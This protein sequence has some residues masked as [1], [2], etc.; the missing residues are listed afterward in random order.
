MLK[1]FQNIYKSCFLHVHCTCTV[2]YHVYTNVY[3]AIEVAAVIYT[4]AEQTINGLKCKIGANDL[5]FA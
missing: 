4:L 2:C 3:Y 1:K 5:L